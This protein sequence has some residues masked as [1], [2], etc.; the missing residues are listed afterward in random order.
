MRFLRESH[1][2]WSHAVVIMCILPAHGPKFAEVQSC[3]TALHFLLMT[4][5]EHS[6]QTV[7]DEENAR[8][9]VKCLM[10]GPGLT[11]GPNDDSYVGGDPVK[12]S[13]ATKGAQ[14][15]ATGGALDDRTTMQKLKDAFIPGSSV[16][17]HTKP[18]KP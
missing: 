7:A 8:L 1:K 9:M 11:G 10:N 15:D 16:G 18:S 13:K 17:N 4:S 12:I 6:I 5:Q 14:Y 2:V 3:R